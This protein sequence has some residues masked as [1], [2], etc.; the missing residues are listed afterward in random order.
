MGSFIFILIILSIVSENI[1]EF[2]VKDELTEKLRVFVFKHGGSFLQSLISCGRCFSG[3]V[4][5]LLSILFVILF[6]L[7]L[8]YSF[9]GAVVILGVV[10]QIVWFGSN[11]IHGLRHKIGDK[12]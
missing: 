10:W 2:F 4:S 9:I 11:I 5:F 12:K 1:T 8:I 3:W 7:Y 6:K